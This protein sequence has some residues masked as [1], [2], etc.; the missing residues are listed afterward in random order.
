MTEPNPFTRREFLYTGLAMVSTLGTVPTFLSQAGSAM[1]DTS[2]RTASKPGVPEDRV[3]VVVQLSGGNDGLNTV[4]PYGSD[5]YHKARPGIGIRQR[6]NLVPIEGADGI[7]LHANLKDVYELMGQRQAAVVQGVGY[8]N[9]NRSHFASMDVWH[10]GTTRDGQQASGWIGRAMDQHHNPDDHG[11]E[12][13]AM[14]DT[15]PLATKGETSRPV[16]FRDAD[17]MRWRPGADQP[18]MGQAYQRMHQPE[19]EADAEATDPAAFIYRTACDAQVASKMVRK[20]TNRKTSVKFP[21][22]SLGRQLENVATMI[23]E[24]LPTRVY[25]VAMGGF[26]THANQRWSHARLLKQFNDAIAA[27]Q[28]ELQAT[29]QSQRVVTMAFSEFGRRVDQNASGGTDHGTAGPMFL[30]GDHVRPGL[31]GE[32]P[33]MTR[34]NQND[35][36]HTVDFRNIYASVLE[37]WMALDSREALGAAYRP[38]R[39]IDPRL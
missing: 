14:G 34:L 9:P 32:H 11:L 25:Y 4:I 7:A 3:L 28:K 23:A 15:A 19:P 31:L 12:C 5:A 22:S 38:A 21:H 16:T 39:V 35:L 13:V 20:A 27:F 18:A 26:D 1:A 29:G 2:M 10:S 8:P 24:G 30:F 36:I 17:T 33:S 6:E 37:N